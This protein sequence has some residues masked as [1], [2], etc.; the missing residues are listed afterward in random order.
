M[1]KIINY[2][3]LSSLLMNMSTP[4]FAYATELGENSSVEEVAE[5]TYE[6]Q[7]FE[8]DISERDTI[9][10]EPE[11]ESSEEEVQSVHTTEKSI[12]LIEENIIEE[13]KDSVN[14]LEKKHPLIKSVE[15]ATVSYKTHVEN[16][17]WQS[18]VKNGAISGT[19]G[20]SLRLEGIRIN[21]TDSSLS[22]G[23]QYRTHVQNEGWQSWKTNDELSGT[24]GKKLRLEAI[25]I[26]L[27]GALEEEYDV[28][29]RVHSETYGWLDWAKNGQSSG[30][31]GLA[32]RLES[33]EVKLVKKGGVAPGSML[34]PYV[35]SQATVSYTT[36]V[37]NEGWQSYA[38]DGAMSGSY[39]KSL[40]LEGIRIKVSDSALSGGIQYRTHVQNEGWQ[41]WKTNDELSGTEGKKLRLEAIQIKLTGSL[42]NYYDVYYRVHSET[43]GW[44]GWAKNGQ[45]SGTEGLAKRLEGIEVC[46][47]KKGSTAPGST[48]RPYV[49]SQATVS[50]TT[51][52]QNE[53]WQGYEKD[54]STSGT[55]GKGLRLEAIKLK[56]S[57][58]ALSGGIQYRTHVQ[59]K[60]WQD[61]KFNDNLSGTEGKALR[62]EAI[63]IK[64]TGALSEY[65]DIYYRVHS[66]TYGWLDWAKNGQSAGTEGFA[67]R[68]EA[69]QVKL[70]KKG[71]T[72]PGS[73]NRPHIVNYGRISVV[74]NKSKN[75]QYAFANSDK[76]YDEYHADMTQFELKLLDESLDQ[77]LLN[78][79]FE[80]LINSHRKSIGV[81]SLVYDSYFEEGTELIAQELAEYGYIAPNGT[82]GHIRPNGER[83]YSAHKEKQYTR[84]WGENIA[85]R[86]SGNNPYRIISEKYL[87]ENFFNMWIN[88]PGH[89]A[90][91]E[92]NY[93][94][95]FSLSVKTTIN[96]N[97]KV[98][99]K[100]NDGNYVTSPASIYTGQGIVAVLTLS[101][102]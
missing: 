43:Y 80:K 46:L 94:T 19:E 30:T 76:F 28:Y 49:I 84:L 71:G 97:T 29:Y 27:T 68:L 15:Q 73:T 7:N 42:A 37:Q 47:V 58:A 77:K 11:I 88:S 52:I 6:N 31:E 98:G 8:D 48:V 102:D 32:K 23:I 53:G 93:F 18:Y 35:I 101:G 79:E 74:I 65:Y 26:K 64:L 87:A 90:N 57:D 100:D 96:G 92:N 59:N 70:V 72:P 3:L 5:E 40:R 54:G 81:K 66:E 9:D 75:D 85:F 17:G 12:N 33:I 45:S 1:K 60:G 10:S 63:Q 14:Q 95:G 2:L 91:M 99:Y 55:S 56:V 86:Y 20:E 67:K 4:T 13:T 39:G 22:G 16:K 36:H 82:S 21:V 41:G 89:R 62:L 83:T 44:L 38:K 34:R 51:H 69:I 78:L 24:E 50:F 25:Q 61:W